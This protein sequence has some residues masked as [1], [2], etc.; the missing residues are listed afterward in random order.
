MRLLRRACDEDGAAG[1][2]V[3][4]DAAH[5]AW[6]DRVVFL[7]DGVIVD[8]AGPIAGPDVPAVRAGE[9][10]ERAAAAG[11]PRRPRRPPRPLAQPARPAIVA[12][13]VAGLVAAV[14][15]TET[16]APPP[17]RRTPPRRSAV[18]SCRYAPSSRYGGPDGDEALFDAL[19]ADSRQGPASRWQRST[20]GAVAVDGLSV[21]AASTTARSTRTRSRPGSSS[22]STARP[23]QHAMPSRSRPPSPSG[24]ELGARRRA[25]R[26]ARSAR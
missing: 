20:V 19:R 26:R 1:V 2:L 6:A 18:P 11:A 9:R 15:L 5:A 23:E 16:A 17:P 8:Q 4:H 21:P 13:P 12:L 22:S 7:R 10:G 3:T 25:D 24:A 14:T